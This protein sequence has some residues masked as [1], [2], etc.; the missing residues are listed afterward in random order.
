[1]YNARHELSSERFSG[2]AAYLIQSWALI[3]N[4]VDNNRFK[5]LDIPVAILYQEML[6]EKNKAPARNFYPIFRDCAQFLDE[7]LLDSY[8]ALS[9]KNNV[10]FKERVRFKRKSFLI[11]A[12]CDAKTSQQAFGD[13][14]HALSALS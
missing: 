13:A 6:L 3:K 4:P 8:I 5:K 1:M 14:K 7:Q 11:S 10:N 9:H 12:S 2:F